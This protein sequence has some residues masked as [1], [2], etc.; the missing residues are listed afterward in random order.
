MDPRLRR[1]LPGLVVSFSATAW[2][3]SGADFGK[4]LEALGHV[5]LPW[6]ALS[7]AVLFTEF[8][9]RAAR[10]KLLLRQLA[11][12]ARFGRLFSATAIGM[13]LNVVLPFRAGDLAR[14]WLGRR[15]TGVGLA[16]LVTI[17]VMERVFDILG[18]VSVFLLMLL[19]LPEHPTAEGEL[20]A[21]LLR[22]G[23]LFGVA[24]VLG[25]GAFFALAAH[26]GAARAVFGRLARLAP[27]PVR[28][29]LLGLFDGFAGGL[30]SVRD[31]KAV[32]GAAALSFLHWFNGSL[33]IW[34]LF[35]AFGL[36]LPFAA[37]CFTTVAIALTVALPQAP[38]FFGVFHV[39]IE[40]T[41]VLWGQPEGP[42]E[43]FA[44]VFW[45]VSFVP[46][47]VSA[48]LL[49]W[50]EGFRVEDVRAEPEALAEATRQAGSG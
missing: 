8:F 37:A 34:V 17:A 44:I 26:E 32:A 48:L 15:E 2:F 40:K 28:D 13:G 9:I 14:P 16:P 33:S 36:D 39:A 11:P 50:R 27:D 45:A 24:G 1:L 7:A 41:L 49:A 42:A 21:N 23:G 19:L 5:K 12:Q 35:R 47:T 4:V 3:V 22:Y 25:L 18:L 43:A 31:R 6:V 30:V 29:R 20:V 46:I 38:G 10:W